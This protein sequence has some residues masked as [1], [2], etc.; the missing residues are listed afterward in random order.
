MF[1]RDRIQYKT[2]EQFRR[3]R[4]A[5]LVVA[6]VHDAMR[7]AVKPGVSTKDLDVL[8][9]KVIRS[10]GGVPSFLGYD[11]GNGPYPGS[12]C[13]SVN[14][15][16]VHAI[17]SP[18]QV[19]E[20]GDLISIDVGAIVDGWHGDAAITLGV[21]E[22]AKELT[23]LVSACEEAM[24]AG[25]RAAATARRLGDISFAIQTSIQDAGDYG[26]VTGFGGHGIG[27][28]MH[29]DPHV[30]NYGRS[31]VGPKIRPGMALALEPMITLGEAEIVEDDD[32]WTVSTAD[33]T[34]A[35]HTE[36]SIA[37]CDDGIWVL[38][39]PDGGAERLGESLAS[40]AR[41]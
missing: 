20:D 25:I 1:S 10:S 28:E 11:I 2:P 35:A 7:E 30:L 40:L 13:S 4:A 22:V 17:P 32:G 39:A 41:Q 5:G 18:T 27:T 8:A 31:G 21:G 38:T 14:D 9:E 29:Q 36:H 24:W 26:I 6:A 12:I 16:V 19:L 33:G 3:M 34:P 15:Q 23:A 37:V